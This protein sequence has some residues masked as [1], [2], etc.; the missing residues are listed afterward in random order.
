[1]FLGTHTDDIS[2][3]GSYSHATYAAIVDHDRKQNAPFSSSDNDDDVFLVRIE[4]ATE[5]HWFW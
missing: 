4:F 3:G 2:S 5:T 1:M